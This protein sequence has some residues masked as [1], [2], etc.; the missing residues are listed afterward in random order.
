MIAISYKFLILVLVLVGRS[1]VSLL[2]SYQII[3]ASAL[4]FE[5]IRRLH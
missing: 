2:L 3:K 1:A 4:N 5:G